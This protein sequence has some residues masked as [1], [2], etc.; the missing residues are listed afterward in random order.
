MVL[1]LPKSPWQT[2]IDETISWKHGSCEYCSPWETLDSQV[3]DEL[4]QFLAY[5]VWN[6]E[7]VLMLL[8]MWEFWM[9]QGYSSKQRE[10]LREIGW[11]VD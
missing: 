10:Q 1:F 7:M 11:L 6:N 8:L 5:C 9:D 2:A 4:P 3:S